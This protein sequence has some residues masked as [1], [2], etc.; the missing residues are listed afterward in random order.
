MVAHQKELSDLDKVNNQREMQLNTASNQREMQL[1]A[2]SNQREMH[3]K[4]SI[5]AHQSKI[6]ILSSRAIIE[7]L[8]SLITNLHANLDKVKHPTKANMTRYTKL[9][10]DGSAP[11]ECDAP[12]QLHVTTEAL[13]HLFECQYIDAALR[14]QLRRWSDFGPHFLDDVAKVL[15]KNLSGDIH[16]SS[17]VDPLEKTS[18][19]PDS[20]S[21]SEIHLLVALS[22]WL[23]VKFEVIDSNRKDVTTDELRAESERISPRYSRQNSEEDLFQI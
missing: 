19:I 6:A 2:T 16:T 17:F 3:L 21:S 23:G 5:A 8:A 15:F 22:V 11:I 14:K 12:N 10:E 18:K 7:R 13:G 20:L 9:A 4:G 1:N